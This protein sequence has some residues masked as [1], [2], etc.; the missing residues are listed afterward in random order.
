MRRYRQEHLFE[1]HTQQADYERDVR[2]RPDDYHIKRHARRQAQYQR[3]AGQTKFVGCDGEGMGLGAEHEYFVFRM[4]RECLVTGAPLQSMELLEFIAAQPEGPIYTIFSGGY[5]FTMILRGLPHVVIRDLLNRDGR[6][7]DNGYVRP[8]RWGELRLDY[9]PHK[10][11]SVGRGTNTI[12]IHDVFGFFQ[13][14]F[15]KALE[16]WEIGTAEERQQIAEGKLRRGSTDVLDPEE[17]RYNERECQLLAEMMEKLNQVT[18]SLT[19]SASPYEGAGAIASSLFR[20]HITKPIKE[21][22]K[23]LGE[24]E[25]EPLTFREIDP[26]ETRGLPTWDAYYGGRF[27]ITAHGPIPVTVYEY[28]I[29]SAYPAAITNLPCLLHG[30][31]A[32]NRKGAGPSDPYTVGYIKWRIP[33]DRPYGPLPHRNKAGN[34]TFPASGAGWYWS[35]EWPTNPEEYEVLETWTWI[36]SCEHRPFYWVADRYQQR[37]AHKQ[38]GRKGQAMMLK[39]GYNSLYGKMAQSVGAAPWRN[40]V[41]AGLVT[42]TCRR[43]LRDAADQKPEDIIMFATDGIYSL[44]PL[45]LPIND[46]LGGWEAGEYE[47]MH[48]VRPGIYFSPDGKA[49]VKS[50]GIASKTITDNAEEIIGAF[51][52]IHYHPEW[53]CSPFWLRLMMDGWGVPLKFNGLISLSLAFAQNRPERAGYFGTLPHTMSYCIF[54]KRLP[55]SDRGL[56]ANFRDGILRSAMPPSGQQYESVG[57]GRSSISH[58]DE[59]LDMVISAP[60]W[61][62]PVQLALELD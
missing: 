4:G 21:R 49:R 23:R 58:N 1:I 28:D 52:R 35:V 22:N 16:E 50:R 5:D 18:L 13:T 32:H 62:T 54:P 34:V 37:K 14:S 36:P 43:W 48:I 45:D 31:W 40:S 29:N 25:Q 33:V 53:L 10:R 9:I 19:L 56:W 39:L 6:T 46:E 41:Y 24:D 42:A 60:D 38:A 7:N 61:A 30:K 59:S 20:L 8:A 12:V 26:A 2:A 55:L 27:E 17:L 15:V 51:N 44:S 3:E 47:G 57:Y 11:L